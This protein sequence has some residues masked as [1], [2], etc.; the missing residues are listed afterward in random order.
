MNILALISFVVLF[1][2]IIYVDV[3]IGITKSLSASYYE[4][5]HGWLFQLAL[6]ITGLLMMIVL[7]EMTAERY[8]FLA[9]FST[10]ALMFV[11][12]APNFKDKLA[13]KVHAVS[14]YISAAASIALVCL[15]GFWYVPLLFLLP[16]LLTIR[17]YGNKI[18]WLEMWCFACVFWLCLLLQI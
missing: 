13:D 18:F 15:M 5:K 12:V 4:V 10:S 6:G 2:Y 1:S 17:F 14:A 9:F 11:A 16:T 8:K 3:T 7:L